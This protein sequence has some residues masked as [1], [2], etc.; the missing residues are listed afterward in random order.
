MIIATGINKS[1]HILNFWG[2]NDPIFLRIARATKIIA[3]IK[4]G[5]IKRGAIFQPLKK[6]SPLLDL[7]AISRLTGFSSNS[8][9]RN[10]FTV[11]SSCLAS[12]ETLFPPEFSLSR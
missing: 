6:A 5:G 4:N 7:A 11:T 10:S 12:S 9:I 3:Y 2:R 1:S 8:F